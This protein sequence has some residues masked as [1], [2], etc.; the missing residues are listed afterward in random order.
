MKGSFVQD[1]SDL[2]LKDYFSEMKNLFNHKTDLK[3]LTEL[4]S[5]GEFTETKPYLVRRQLVPKD[6]RFSSI[7]LVYESSELVQSVF[8]YL[9]T[10]LSSA[11][12]LFGDP[13]FHYVP[14]GGATMIGFYDHNKQF[15]G[16]ESNYPGDVKKKLRK[17]KIIKENGLKEIKDDLDISFISFKVNYFI[18]K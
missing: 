3:T 1:L 16:F 17:Y 8:W 14:H 2:S 15:S 7:E 4:L 13:R 6:E 11:V 18:E 9:K 5:N 10:N 12:E